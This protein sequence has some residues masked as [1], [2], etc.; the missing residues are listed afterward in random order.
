MMK[1]VKMK[2]CISFDSY[3]KPQPLLNKI[4]LEVRC[5]SFDSYIK[6]QQISSG[7]DVGKCCI[8]FDSYIKPQ[9]LCIVHICLVRCISFDSYIK[10]QH[11]VLLLCQMPC[12]ISFDSYIKP[13][14]L[15]RLANAMHVVYLLIPTSNHNALHESVIVLRLYIF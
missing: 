11:S 6:P 7:A 5:I 2:C 15:K 8:S 3:I 13:Q 12:C 1:L 4:G 9:P 14:L 10:P